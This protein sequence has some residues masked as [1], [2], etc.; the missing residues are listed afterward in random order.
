MKWVTKTLPFILTLSGTLLRT[1]WADDPVYFA[2][3]KLKEKV[4]AKLFIPDPTPVDMLGLT[5]LLIPITW[6]RVNP[7]T[8]LTGLEYATNLT[9]LNLKYHM[10]TDLSLLA[11]LVHL[12]SLDLLGIGIRDISP[13]SGLKELQSLDLELNEISDVSPLSGL[14]KLASLTLHRNR[15]SDIS[16][17]VSL[18]SLQWLDLRALPLNQDA[19]DRY[20][21]QIRANNPDIM[22][23][24]DKPVTGL[25]LVISSTVGGSVVA[26]GEGTFA[27]VF[28]EFLSL[29]AKA[30]PG[31]VFTGWSGTRS[32]TQNPLPLTMD[33]NYTLQANFASSL[34][35]LHIDDDAPADPG[36]DN[37]AISDPEENGTPEHPF[38]SICEAIS[39][40]TNRATLFVRPGTYRETID[41]L[42][43]Q[44]VLTGFDPNDPDRAGW[45]VIDGDGAGPV[46]NLSHGEMT[47]CVLRGLIITG[48]QDPSVAAIR[49]VGSSPTITNCLI[50][51]NRAA[52]LTGAAVLCEDSN[53]A[54]V[55]CTIVDNHAGQ[56]GAGLFLVNSR[57]TV[58]NSILWGNW[59]REIQTEGDD[60]PFICH[61]AVAG[62]WLGSGNLKADPLFAR[63]GRWVDRDNPSVAV[64]PDDAGAVW[65]MGDYH[66]QSQVGRWDPATNTWLKD[67]SN[68]PCIDAGDP[69]SPVGQ[70]PSPNGGIINLGVYGGT[71][72]ASKSHRNTPFP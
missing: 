21:P 54:F 42:G 24:Y 12:R 57:V 69:T 70:E 14:S 68:S 3:L 20:I 31:F 43:K 9:S 47:N 6:A 18:K 60:L 65:V 61:S 15:I 5:E 50:V 46:V 7:I 32:S 22:L 40:A 34:R 55:N 11:G 66:L 44:I 1:A 59:P 52:A 30:D 67:L 19:Y 58:V 16:P 4:E 49:C 28:G 39:V 38:D 64:T 62:G 37:S 33:Q 13:L 48:G 51:G 41:L 27:A 71:V 72:Q 63:L 2:D 8:D 26:P 35:T 17:L 29:E 10:T 36:P 23:F 53:A 25:V 45:P 56:Y